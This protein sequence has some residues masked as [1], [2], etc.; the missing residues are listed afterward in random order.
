MIVKMTSIQK[1]M[2][3]KKEKEREGQKMT[4]MEEHIN[5]LNAGNPIYHI[6]PYIPT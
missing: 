5:V 6:Q 4:M 3:M 1:K 2:M